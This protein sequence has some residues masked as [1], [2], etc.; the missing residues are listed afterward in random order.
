[1]AFGTVLVLLLVGSAGAAWWRASQRSALVTAVA[2]VPADTQR[3]AWT[4]WAAVRRTLAEPGLDRLLSKGYDADLTSASAMLSSAAALQDALGFSPATVSWELLAQSTSGVVDVIGLTDPDAVRDA[5]ERAGWTRTGTVW[6]DEA[7]TL[8]VKLGIAPE[9]SYIAIRD[10]VLFASDDADHLA[11]VLDAEESPA[12]PIAE[13]VSALGDPLS[14]VVYGGDYACGHLAMSQADDVDQAQAASLLKAV[15][16]VDPMTGFAMAVEPDRGVR[17]AMAF[18]SHA[19][20]VHNA[21]ARATLAGGPAPGQGGD[22]GERFT[23]GRVEARGDLLT[24]ELR[25]VKGT[26]VLSDLSN[27]PVLFASC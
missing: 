20:A 19:R 27:G 4:D 14:A 23:L 10:G 22:F 13:V 8:T 15:D 25:P 9:F 5:V 12:G 16:G 3:Y 11:S 17:V 6:G 7:G 24:M 21:D 18:E 1:L 26:A 2:L